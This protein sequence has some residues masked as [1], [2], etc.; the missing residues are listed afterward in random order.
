MLNPPMHSC[1]SCHSALLRPPEAQALLATVEE[2]LQ[3]VLQKEEDKRRETEAERKRIEGGFPT[4]GAAN[5]SSP[6]EPQA[7]KVMSLNSKSKKITVLTKVQRATPPSSL[8]ASR[9]QTP[10]LEEGLPKR[11]PPPPAEVPVPAA[12]KVKPK[13]RPWMN[14]RENIKYVDPARL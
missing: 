11:V 7:Y 8:S 9:A 10:D 4:L 6:V 3:A 13:D 5:T 2:E 1:P 14:L 12:P